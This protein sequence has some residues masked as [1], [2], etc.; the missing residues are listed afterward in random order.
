MKALIN[1][2]HRRLVGRRLAAIINGKHRLPSPFLPSGVVLVEGKADAKFLERLKK[3]HAHAHAHGLPLKRRLG[4]APT[5]SPARHVRL[6]GLLDAP[7]QDL[8]A[9][10]E[11]PRASACELAQ[12][13]QDIAACAALNSRLLDA[14]QALYAV[15]HGRDPQRYDLL[16]RWGIDM[17]ADDAWRMPLRAEAARRTAELITDI[18]GTA[19][20]TR[21][22][23]TGHLGGLKSAPASTRHA[24]ETRHA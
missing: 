5:A 19:P 21:Q 1:W 4:M 14:L 18:T 8:P 2:W 9:F 6:G 23:H 22:P 12:A 15:H 17:D 3:D 7:L 24:Q 13:R 16:E 11:A 20:A 10:R